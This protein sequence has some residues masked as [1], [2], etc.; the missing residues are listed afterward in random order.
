M[1]S[2]SP[3]PPSPG[4]GRGVIARDVFFW[5]CAVVWALSILPSLLAVLPPEPAFAWADQ[6]LDAPTF[7][8]VFV[9]ASLRVRHA[10]DQ[11]E[12]VFW[13]FLSGCMIAWLS[14]RGL[15]LIVPYEERGMRFDLTTDVLYL[16]GYLCVALAMEGRP[17]QRPENGPGARERRIESLGTLVFGFGLL[18]YFALVPSVFNPEIYASWVSSM[19]LYAV[20]DVYLLVRGLEILRSGLAPGWR[21]PLGW[22]C[23]SFALWLVGDLTEGLMYMEAIPFVEPGTPWDLLWALSPLTLLLAV[24]SRSWAPSR[25]RAT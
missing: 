2:A 13:R 9:A 23:V 5:S 14:V 12:K 25:L 7:A 17:D 15:Y 16:A 8:L 24:R 10:E 18:S 11:R 6:F 4:E 19:L 21:A 22:L 20:L 3:R 1:E